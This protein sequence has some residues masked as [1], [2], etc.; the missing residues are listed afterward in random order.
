MK[1]MGSK[2]AML[3]NGLGKL[4]REEGATATRIVDLF[5]GSG[6]VAWFAAQ[7]F[8]VPVVAVDLQSYA[9]VLSR[10][11]I[12][13]THAVDAKAI[14][15]NWRRRAADRWNDAP[16]AKEAAALQRH[17]DLGGRA[18]VKEARALCKGQQSQGLIWTAY[19]GHYFSPWQAMMFDALRTSLPKEED[20]AKVAHAA[21]LVA[22]TRCAAA[23]GHTAQPFQPTRGAKRFLAESWAKD[24]WEC[25][26]RALASIAPMKAKRRGEAHVDDAVA[27]TKNL[28]EGDLV[29]LDPPYSGVHYSRF[30]HVLETLAR[31]KAGEVSGVGRYPPASERPRSA[32]SQKTSSAR[33]FRTLMDRLAKRQCRVI[34]TFPAAAASNGLSGQTVEAIAAEYFDVEKRAVKTRFSTMGGNNEGR[35]ARQLSDELILLLRP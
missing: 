26:E 16:L 29:F 33:S 22:A 15:K 5:S 8:S 4:L 18:S 19:G 25:V 21:L 34:V 30:Y 2:R 27:F 7:E 20:E 12:E 23:P 24:P 32:F 28:R 17:D 35:S 6:S 11:V 9:A 31:Q 1:Y 14:A 3:Q 13:R 10:S